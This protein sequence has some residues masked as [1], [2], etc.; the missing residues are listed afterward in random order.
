M[1]NIVDHLLNMKVF[2]LVTSALPLIIIIG[3]QFKNENQDN[4]AYLVKQM[5]LNKFNNIC[6]TSFAAF[7]I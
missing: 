6:F 1:K 5:L 3:T 7:G 2:V 4:V